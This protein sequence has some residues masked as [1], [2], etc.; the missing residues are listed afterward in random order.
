MR[1]ISAQTCIKIRR[2]FN[3][4]EPH[5]TIQRT[6]RGC[7]SSVGYRRE[8]A[9]INLAR[10]CMSQATIQ[11]E[12]LH[13]LAF[14]HMHNHPDRD[15]YVKIKYE[16]IKPGHEHNF[17][18]KTHKSVHDFGLGYDYKSLMH[19]GGKHFSNNGKNTIVPLK[20]G[21]SIGTAEALS[22]KDII[23]LKKVYC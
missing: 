17:M 10:A 14:V 2:T 1:N 9:K 6:S 21:V 19:Y 15:K 12:I 18:I 13:A 11:H 5:V 20:D 16:N 22:A 23:K 8:T 7:W 4:K 3:L